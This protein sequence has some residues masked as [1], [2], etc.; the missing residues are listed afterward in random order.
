MEIS[1]VFSCRCSFRRYC[2]TTQVL[3]DLVC[4]LKWDVGTISEG[5]IQWVMPDIKG[6]LDGT[7]SRANGFHIAEG[8]Q[9]CSDAHGISFKVPQGWFLRSYPGLRPGNFLAIVSPEGIE[10]PRIGIQRLASTP[11][12][13][14]QLLSPKVAV[15]LGIDVQHLDVA[16][17]P[18]TALSY[19][20]NSL[21]CK[22]VLMLRANRV[23]VV[24]LD[25]DD[26]SEGLLALNAL[27]GSWLWTGV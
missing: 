10:L 14:D 13:R 4:S 25:T 2:Q 1:V 11:I 3:D 5:T 6:G 16:G 24:R 15:N 20:K 27:L 23:I 7:S 9:V 17:V 19:E 18:A 21:R 12:I 22:E 8:N 26:S